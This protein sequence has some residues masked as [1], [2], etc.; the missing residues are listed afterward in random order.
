ML[1][2]VVQILF[3]VG[4][5]APADMSLEYLHPLDLGLTTHQVPE[6]WPKPKAHKYPFDG[7]LVDYCRVVGPG[8]LVGKGL[9]APTDGGKVGNEFVHFL[10]VKV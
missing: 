3:D 7:G 6:G 9:K 5:S 1:R 10:L 8:V 2:Y 4:E